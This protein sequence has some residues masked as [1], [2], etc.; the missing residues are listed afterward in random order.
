M[1]FLSNKLA[2]EITGKAESAGHALQ[3]LNSAYWRAMKNPTEKAEILGS[4]QSIVKAITVKFTDV[5]TVGQAYVMLSRIPA[6]E[7]PP[8]MA[9]IVEAKRFRFFNEYLGA[10]MFLDGLSE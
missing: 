9:D 3:L 6:D 5:P 8:K 2:I 10:V 1:I 7:L 4:W